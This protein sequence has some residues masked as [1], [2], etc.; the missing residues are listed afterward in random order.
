MN[1]FNEIEKLYNESI[2]LE[3]LALKVKSKAEKI[4]NDYIEKNAFKKKNLVIVST[5]KSVEVYNIQLDKEGLLYITSGGQFRH[6]E[7]KV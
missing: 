4:E 3:R 6:H 5:G 2:K 7:V 1:P